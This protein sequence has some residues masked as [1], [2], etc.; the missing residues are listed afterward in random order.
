MMRYSLFGESHGPAIGI[1]LQGVP[2]G[3]S[4][5]M[6]FIQGELERR[7]PGRTL[8]ST[9]RKEKDEVE[10]VSGAFEG[11]AT[12]T[13]LCGLIRNTDMR[14]RDYAATRWLARPGHA[15]FTSHLHYKGFED[16]RGGGHFSGRL[17]APLVFAGAVAKLALRE[18]GIEVLA[19]IRQIEN[20]EDVPMDPAS[21]DIGALRAAGQKPLP[22]LS[23]E[24]AE[25]MREAIL[26][27]RSEGDSVGGIVE[28]FIFGMPAGVGSPDFDESV[29]SHL[30]RHIFAVPAVKGLE[31]GTGFGFASMRGSKANDVFVPAEQ[32]VLR[33]RTNNN[34]GINGGI[35]NG[36]P[37]VFRVVIKPTASIAQEQ[38]TVDMLT[39]EAA[40]LVISGRHDPCILSRAIPVIEAAAALA[41]CSVPGVLA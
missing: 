27:A 14:S 29:E 12:G 1:V 38:D 26:K 13:P 15:D 4:L 30:A 23:D 17:T 19:R 7:S 34:G 41:V 2:S 6:D 40:K 16:Y 18:R 22:V 8:M 11:R 9:S 32:G 37:V 5:D 31:F 39:G 20:I 33:T 35:A 10:I 3:L 25:A 28:C 36:M 21:P 24:K